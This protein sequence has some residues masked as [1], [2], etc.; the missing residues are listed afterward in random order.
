MTCT[1]IKRICSL[2]DVDGVAPLDN[3]ATQAGVPPGRALVRRIVEAD[4]EQMR[5][6]VRR[7][8]SVCIGVHRWFHYLA[9][10]H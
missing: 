5:S 3:Q 9:R 10:L 2:H 6:F 1:A 7:G 4:L 8:P